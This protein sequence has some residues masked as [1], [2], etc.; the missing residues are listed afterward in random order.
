MKLNW[1]RL[2]RKIHYWGAVICALPILIVI[3]SGVLLLVKKEFEWIQ[4][5]TVKTSARVSTLTLK[6]ILVSVQSI[7]DLDIKGWQDIDRLDIRPNKGVIKV[8]TQQ[9]IEV[10]LDWAT[11]EVL[12]VAQRRSDVIESIHDGTFFHDA[13]KLGLFLPAALILLVLW[14]TGI[15]LFLLPYLR[16]GKRY[17]QT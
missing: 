4:P 10:Q 15:Y 16:K 9:S 3:G 17:K 5:T 2:S 11:G 12:K 14:V 1:N 13:V 8:Q 6:Q 7:S